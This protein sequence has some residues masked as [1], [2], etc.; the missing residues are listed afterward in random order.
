[1]FQQLNNQ[2]PHACHLIN[3][4]TEYTNFGFTNLHLS[5]ILLKLYPKPVSTINSLIYKLTLPIKFNK[6]LNLTAGKGFVSL[7]T[8]FTSDRIFTTLTTLILVSSL[9][10]CILTLICFVLSWYL[11]FLLSCVALELSQLIVTVCYPKP[12]S[13]TMTFHRSAF[14]TGSIN[15]RYSASILERAT[16]NYNYAFQLIAPPYTMNINQWK[17]FFCVNH[18]HSQYLHNQQ[19]RLFPHQ[20]FHIQYQIIL[21]L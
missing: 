6:S 18:L 17:T 19:L 3:Y 16:T 13:N 2:R 15:V 8:R 14:S 4:L 12:N 9:I 20:L 10:K 5:S 11:V 21:F 7:S 1:M